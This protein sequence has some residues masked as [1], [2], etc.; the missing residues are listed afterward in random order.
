MESDVLVRPP[1]AVMGM[2]APEPGRTFDPPSPEEL[3]RLYASDNDQLRRS[4]RELGDTTSMI[5]SVALG[6]AKLVS[7]AGLGAGENMVKIPRRLHE[8]MVGAAIEL[9]DDMAGNITV[10]IV[11]RSPDRIVTAV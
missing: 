10:K 8:Q 2:K 3:V 5:A 1:V 7:D 11:E 6:L 4:L 9:G